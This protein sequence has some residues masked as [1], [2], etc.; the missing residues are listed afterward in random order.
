MA[1]KP[2]LNLQNDG[3]GFTV[4]RSHAL[5]KGRLLC[6]FSQEV[7]GKQYLTLA[8]LQRIP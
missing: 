8:K 7:S 1:W 2:L 6:N 5:H 3:A 4:R